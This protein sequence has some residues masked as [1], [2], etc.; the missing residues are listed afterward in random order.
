MG[1]FGRDPKFLEQVKMNVSEY[2]FKK[3]ADHLSSVGAQN[4]YMLR[5]IITGNYGECVPHYVRKE[6]YEIIQ[7]NISRIK[8]KKGFIQDVAKENGKF[9]GFNLSDI[10]EYMDESLFQNVSRD[11]ILSSNPGAKF[12]YWNLM[13]PRNMAEINNGCSRKNEL[14]SAL[15][16]KDKGFFY[17]CFCIDEFTNK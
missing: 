12:A 9:D 1:N 17:N 7:K 16:K 5:Y 8:L 11:L 15:T 3:A 14:S 6:N 10:F 4:N 13:V 2:I